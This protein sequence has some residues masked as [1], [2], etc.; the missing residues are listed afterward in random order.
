[1]RHSVLHT[2]NFKLTSQMEIDLSTIIISTIALSVFFIPV[3]YDYRSKNNRGIKKQLFELVKTKNLDIDKYDI[4]EK[5]FALCVDK[6]SR[7][8]FYRNF[9]DPKRDLLIDLEGVETCKLDVVNI[10]PHK[11]DRIELIL[12]GK[13][14]S[15]KITL[16]KNLIKSNAQNEL[17]LAKKWN[18]IINNSISS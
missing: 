10:T 6:N 3:L 9:D 11:I 14:S 15:R 12:K 7:H 2:Y 8:V 17:K 5:S 16:F 13:P 4:W 1:M 18:T